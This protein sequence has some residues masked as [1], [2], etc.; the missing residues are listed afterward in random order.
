MLGEMALQNGLIDEIG[1]YKE[2]TDYLRAQIGAE[3]VYCW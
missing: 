2:V 1:S 3:P